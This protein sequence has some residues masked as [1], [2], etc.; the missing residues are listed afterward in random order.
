MR[1]I[2]PASLRSVDPL[3]GLHPLV[4]QTLARRGMNTPETARAFLDPEAYSPAPAT[5]L[6]GL[7]TAAE[8]VERAIRN[9]EHICVWGDFDVDGQ[10][11][12]TV[13]FQTLRVLDADVTFHIP[14]RG[15]ES[16]GVNIPHL[17]E[18]IDQG[19][20]LILTCD[21]GITAHDAV[22]YA[23]TRGVEMV[24][25]DHH[26]LPETLPKAVAIVN[27]KLLPPEHPLATLA[28]VGVAYKLAEDLIARFLSETFSP[29]FL[30]DLVALGLVADLAI[31]KGDAR[32]MVQKGLTAL[33]STQR[34]GL[35][36]MMEMAELV[37]ANLTEEHIGFV[38]GPRLNALGRLGDANPA[39]EL[40]TTSNSGRARLLATQLENYN[41]QR[42][43]LCSQ[44]TQA[45]EAQLQ[46]DP[47]LLANPVLLLGHPA[48]PGGVVG[49]VASRL[50]DRYGKP[51]IVFS[52]PDNEPARGSARSVEGLNITAA[53]AAQKDLLLNFGGH[54]MAAGLALEKEKLPE[55]NRRL[56]KTVGNMLGETAFAEPELRIDAWLDLPEI[57]LELAAALESL[58][59][60]GPGNPKLTLATHGLILQSAMTIGRNKEHL[61]LTVVNETGKPQTVL[62][63]SGAGETIPNGKF[64][65][66]YT[67]RASDWRGGRQVQM[68]FVDFRVVETLPVEIKSQKPE[69]VDFRNMKDPYT[70]L[71]NF[72]NQ[73]SA[74]IWAEAEAKK[75]VGG[76]DRNELEPS[77][78]LIIWTIPPSPGELK[79]ALDTVKPKLV[80]LVCAHPTLE[81]TDAFMAR[82]TG[83]MKYAINQREG[84][85]TYAELATGTAQRRITVEQGFHWLVS[86]GKITLVRQENDVLWVAPGKT[87]NDLGG[88]AQLRQEVQALLSETAAY[89]AYFKRA[90]KDTLLP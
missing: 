74:L 75:E 31:L 90:D 84:K 85:I 1:W 32:Y 36:V 33:R 10:T 82:L 7:I 17:K 77:D 41:V 78:N 28:G 89:R 22:E 64:D 57:T 29:S 63:W 72:R 14:V 15:Q 9:R 42:Q 40:L 80:T 79:F 12:T 25:T 48:W 66:A 21:T 50:V 16:H 18:I 53:I 34:L 3:P 51:A 11:S 4:A 73:P 55:F 24:I 76:K 65:L 81:I 67:V 54:P 45:A 56:S 8:R 86:S 20:K 83:L 37:P 52:T 46:A 47:A 13:L 61:K 39:V 30:L 59:P 58:A 60:F 43:L 23:R 69:L 6:P 2:E 68:E 38:L 62:W 44:V 5:D 87:I 27:P 71:P 35:Q 49:I 19:A 70:L 88:A 26:D